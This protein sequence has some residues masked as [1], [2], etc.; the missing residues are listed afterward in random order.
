VQIGNGGTQQ[1]TATGKYSDGSSKNLTSSVTWNSSVV[2]VARITNSGVAWASQPG[3]TSILASNG[4][5]HA[6]AT[7]TVTAAPLISISITPVN[8]FLA[9]GTS[10]QLTAIGVFQDGSTAN[11]TTSVNWATSTPSIASISA[12][13]LLMG[14]KTGTARVVASKGSISTAV[15]VTVTPAILAS[16]AISPA[17]ASIAKGTTQQFSALGTFTDGTIQDVTSVVA[18]TSSVPTVAS[19]GAGL[20]SGLA[21]GNT[22]IT[23]TA[24]AISA[25]AALTVTN[26]TVVSIT[27]SPANPSLVVG[28]F[29]QFAASG[30]FSDSS[31]QDISD[32]A[33]WASSMPTVAGMNSAGLASGISPGT[34]VISASFEQVTGS[35][36]V[37][38]QAPSL[39]SISVTPAMP[40]IA[41]TTSESFFVTGY[42]DDGSTQTLI[43]ATWSSSN[44]AVASMNGNLAVSR[45][46]GTTTVTAVLGSFTAS[47]TL[48]VTSATLVSIAVTP[49]NASIA[50][51]T[52]KPFFAFG[53]F[54]DATTQNLSSLVTWNSSNTSVAMM[55]QDTASGVG[56][57]TTVISAAFDGVI[58]S[59]GLTVTQA[60]LASLAVT[61]A[62]PVL[63]VGATQQ[64]SA[65]GHFSDG[66]TQDMTP[67][68]TWISSA[69]SAAT[70]SSTGMATSQGAGTTTISATYGSM[71]AS[72]TVNVSGASLQSLTVTP[73]TDTIPPGA[74]QQFAATG[75][76]SD[77]TVQKVTTMARWTS[78]NANVAT[79]GNTTTSGLVSGVSAGWTRISAVLNSV[80]ASAVVNV[81]NATL[82]ALSISPADPSL[83]LGTNQ[84]LTATGTFSDGNTQDLTGWV[85]WGSSNAQVCVVNSSGYAS[86][87]GTGTATVT[88]SFGSVS[89]TTA[90][91]VY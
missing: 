40:N 71:S 59:A 16:L 51:G 90:V 52:T 23:A 63:V 27:L 30:V 64:F 74:G 91:T 7:L 6:S 42:Y 20:V 65:T 48:T 9:A 3:S 70:I 34:A 44:P 12:T 69:S 61:P 58:G 8:P 50:P 36:S 86:T 82:V 31:T 43:N 35:S 18:W 26:A 29:Q 11:L 62:N 73:Q 4:S 57:G 13:G 1:F 88:A 28:L 17:T 10:L 77:G 87:S 75:T 21:A 5:I 49:A 79:V 72:T 2:T 22:V 25:S 89:T 14:G 46:P 56:G 19:A 66:S 78:S 76:Y 38:V 55:N 24:G 67:L 84:Q 80:I 81:N 33:T 85:N 39:V 68:V 60:R 47:T 83:R 54:S 37:S 53:T 32:V 45:Q 41:N 15:S